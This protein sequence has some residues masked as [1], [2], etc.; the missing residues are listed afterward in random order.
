MPAKNARLDIEALIVMPETSKRRARRYV[1]EQDIA[2]P[3]DMC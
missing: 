1:P 3:P 2:L